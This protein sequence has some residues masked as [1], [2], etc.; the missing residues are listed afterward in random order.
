MIR[1]TKSSRRDRPQTNPLLSRTKEARTSKHA[2][3][4][5]AFVWTLVLCSPVA[6]Q[7]PLQELGPVLET[8]GSIDLAFPE[9]HSSHEIYR[10]LERA[11][12]VEITLERTLNDVPVT[13]ELKSAELEDALD[14]LNRKLDAFYIVRGPR[15]ISVAVDTPQ[16]R[17]RYEPH[18][19]ARF[20]IHDV[21]PHTAM[22]SLRALVD[23]RKVAYDEA[24]STLV[25]RGSRATVQHAAR[26]LEE[27]DQPRDVVELQVEAFAVQS[28]DRLAR[29]GST[30]TTADAR[31]AL[32]SVGA[33][34]VLQ[35]RATLAVGEQGGMEAASQPYV[36]K[37]LGW[38][39]LVLE[40]RLRAS[41]E[42]SVFLDA[43]V[44]GACVSPTMHQ[45]LRR[46]RREQAVQARIASGH[47]VLVLEPVPPAEPPI[48]GHGNTC[49]LLAEVA[50]ERTQFVLLLTPTLRPA[51][52]REL[53][54]LA[55][56]AGTGSQLESAE[57][58]EQVAD[59]R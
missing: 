49:G 14:A 21:S 59:S 13:L 1:W 38:E 33:R 40:H 36:G 51:A 6:A 5:A 53:D 50:S 56:A 8:D 57:S 24:G 41:D 30:L 39:G 9:R 43:R 3:L 29:L 32:R 15:S 54:A 37:E 11:F 25:V 44:M 47:S 2:V 52:Y 55:W 7:G 35:Q 31:A 22:D 58:P 4:V 23:V 12:D 27:L 19:V 17:R 10:A 26:V 42:G 16:N 18:Y 20:R 34:P 48:N 45:S 46:D 28:L